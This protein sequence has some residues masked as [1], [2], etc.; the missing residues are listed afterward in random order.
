MLC[1]CLSN[2]FK[3]NNNYY[4]TSGSLRNYHRNEVNYDVN[5][6]SGASDH[7]ENNNKAITIYLFIYEYLH[8]IKMSV[9]FT[10]IYM[11]K[12]TAILIYHVLKGK[13]KRSLSENSNKKAEKV[14]N[15]IKLSRMKK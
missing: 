3:Y 5:E 8:R 13:R 6:N 15:S 7:R 14:K 1:Q 10:Y 2:L 12:K 9:I 11:Y 4:M